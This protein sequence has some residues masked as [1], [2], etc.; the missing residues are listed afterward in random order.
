MTKRLL[1]SFTVLWQRHEELYCGIFLAALKKLSNK[2]LTGNEN[3]ISL[4]LY[5]IL[6]EICFTLGKS[7]N[8]EI[9]TPNPECPIS[10]LIEH[11]I[12]DESIGKCPDFTCNHLNP[13]AEAPEEHEIPLHIECKLLGQPKPSSPSWEFNK[14]YVTNGIKRFDSKRH[15]YGKRALSGLMI[16]YI[17]SME[18]RTILDE[19]NN[20][21]R[22]ELPDNPYIKFTFKKS[23]TFQSYQELKRKTVKP[24]DFNL[25]HIWVDL[26]RGL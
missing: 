24:S 9:S 2:K 8:I 1:P 26:R 11:E 25:I 4:A 16:G 20:C 18:P 17:I 10:P 21:Q 19:V 15:E 14:N 6:N 3:S 7:K 5:P 13:F 22:K 12:D 23:K